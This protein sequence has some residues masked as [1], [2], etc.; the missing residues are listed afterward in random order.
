MKLSK[1]SS[2]YL[3]HQASYSQMLVVMQDVTQ[4]V[5]QWTKHF[6]SPVYLSG[7]GFMAGCH[8]FL[9]HSIIPRPFGHPVKL[10]FLMESGSSLGTSKK[11]AQLVRSPSTCA[12]LSFSSLSIPPHNGYRSR[13]SGVHLRHTPGNVISH[14]KTRTLNKEDL[15]PCVQQRGSLVVN[16]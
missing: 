6:L 13:R 2:T 5:S 4:E 11:A 16:S 15:E 9:T 14:L 7:Q 12:I 10:S 8:D 3:Q 1:I